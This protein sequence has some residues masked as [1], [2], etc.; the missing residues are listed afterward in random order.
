MAKKKSDFEVFMELVFISN[1]PQCEGM[2]STLKARIRSMKPK[3]ARTAKP[4]PVA[5]PKAG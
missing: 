3:E 5:E 4:K 2:I 1:I